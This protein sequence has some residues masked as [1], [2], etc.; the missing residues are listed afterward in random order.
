MRKIFVLFFFIFSAAC[1]LE[2]IFPWQTLESPVAVG[3]FG[4]SIAAGD[5]NGDGFRDIAVGAPFTGE[6][7]NRR[8]NVY[9]YFGPSLDLPFEIAPPEIPAQLGICVSCAG[10]FNGDGY[11]DLL[12]GANTVRDTGA[13]YIFFGGTHFDGIADVA[14]LG[15]NRVDNFGYACSGIGDINGD[16]YA[17]V[18]IGALYYRYL[19]FDT[20]FATYVCVEHTCTDLAT[21]H[22][23]THPT[24]FADTTFIDTFRVDSLGRRTGRLYIYYGG[25]LPDSLPDIIITGIDSLDDFGNPVSG[26]SDFNG[27]AVP[28]LFI[29]AVQAGGY[30]FKNGAAYIFSGARLASGETAPEHSFEGETIFS[31]FGGCASFAGDINGDGLAD[32]LTGAYNWQSSDA[33]TSRGKAYVIFGARPGESVRISSF[34]GRVPFDYFAGTIA[35]IG[36]YDSDRFAD[37]ALSADFDTSFS[38]TPGTVFL[39]L[40][41]R[42]LDTMPDYFCSGEFEGQNFGANIAPLGDVSGDGLS[43]FA[44]A[45]GTWSEAC[46]VFIYNGF[47][48]FL[49]FTGEIIEPFDGAVSSNIRQ[50]LRFVCHPERPPLLPDSIFIS[51]DGTIYYTRTVSFHA[52]TIE[53]IP[54]ENLTYGST[55]ELCIDSAFTAYGDPLESPLCVHL[56]IDTLPPSFVVSAPS[57]SATVAYHEKLGAFVFDDQNPNGFS[58]AIILESDSMRLDIEKQLFGTKLLVHTRVSDATYADGG[59]HYVICAQNICDSCDYGGNNCHTPLCLHVRHARRY[60]LPLLACIDGKACRTLLLGQQNGASDNYDGTFDIISPPPPPDVV[61]VVFYETGLPLSR[62]IKSER[63][64]SLRFVLW[65]RDSSDAILSWNREVLPPM[66][67]TINGFDM[68]AETT[69]TL[70]AGESVGINIWCTNVTLETLQFHQRWNALGFGNFTAEHNM[71]VFSNIGAI[72]PVYPLSEGYY[73]GTKFLPSRGFFSYAFAPSIL[74]IWTFPFD[75]LVTNVSSRWNLLS[76]A[77]STSFATAPDSSALMPAYFFDGSAYLEA[78]PPFTPNDGVWIFFVRPAHV[79]WHR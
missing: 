72:T 62:N 16:T 56:T 13:A 14:F 18:A 28:D 10:D 74:P 73:A 67:L 22:V 36:D 71:R 37:F 25:A 23:F 75:S 38:T 55:F 61:N 26:G 47:A 34:A 12:V 29:G 49:P 59:E 70:S 51:I 69:F 78:Y 46:K 76:L 77:A 44:V 24:F 8:G 57:D 11:D 65:N 7:F 58:Q 35:P 4:W 79:I 1:A 17:D 40:G 33:D 43:D 30:T 3:R 45:T 15:E 52:D 21:G 27:D 54:T 5:F 41:A 39:Y 42:D 60:L 2:E 9:V 32:A 66:A 6:T 50:R 64:D 68:F 31:V 53:I 19:R 20:T 63:A 48:R